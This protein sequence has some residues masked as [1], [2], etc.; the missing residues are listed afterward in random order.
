VSQ[1]IAA[2]A[3]ERAPSM[4]SLPEATWETIAIGAFVWLTNG[5]ILPLML[6]YLTASR[7]LSPRFAGGLLTAGTLLGLA[8]QPLGG[9][10]VDRI[11]PAR[12]FGVALSVMA[13]GALGLATAQEIRLIVPASV[14]SGIGTQ[15]A[16]A[17]SPALLFSSVSLRS[18]FP[19]ASAAQYMAANAFSGTGGLIAG[20]FVST[21]RPATFM[22]LF[23][24][25]AVL[26]ASGALIAWIR[27]HRRVPKRRAPGA[28]HGSVEPFATDESGRGEP[29]RWGP[30]W[31]RLFGGPF[32]SYAFRWAFLTGLLFPLLGNQQLFS[33]LPLHIT[34]IGHR[35]TQVVGIAFAANTYTVVSAQILALRLFRGRP[36]SIAVAVMFATLVLA[37]I[38]VLLADRERG[39]A[40]MAGY[41]A[42]AALIGLG[43]VMLTLT[44]PPV[45]ALVA[46]PE[47]L[48]RYLSTFTMARGIVQVL[49]P[50][51][52]GLL[53][54]P[55]GG[56]LLPAILG[57][58]A[59]ASGLYLAR[60][61]R[62]LP[63]DVYRI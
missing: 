63:P 37:W 53:V 32:S 6:V 43:E 24:F 5:M 44:A 60:R 40:Q 17:T 29:S 51:L 13:A 62:G 54:D 31:G 7:G 56:A 12:A 8:M 18:H 27:L 59:V 61:A 2:Q 9:F 15:L 35:P 25:Q 47:Q 16:M 57:T 50:T 28:S 19:V 3:E 39:N 52:V 10:L 55:L 33:G 14:V 58:L 21:S 23:L 45:P 34:R 38:G 4:R 49:A 42:A 20:F 26:L 46:P 22:T 1:Q 41:V 30:R 36:R 11:G 48:G